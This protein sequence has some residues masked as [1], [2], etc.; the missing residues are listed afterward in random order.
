MDSKGIRLKTWMFAIAAAALVL[1]LPKPLPPILGF[2]IGVTTLAAAVVRATTKARWSSSFAW[3]LAFY[4]LVVLASVYACWLAAWIELGRP[5]RP[6]A[7]DPKDLGAAV[8]A[9]RV[10][11]SLGL[12]GLLPAAAVGFPVV[13]VRVYTWMME[14]PSPAKSAAGLAAAAT[15]GWALPF[16]L[17]S[18]DPGWVF[19]WFFD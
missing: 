5:P 8:V 14:R 2:A 10:A 17:S 13:M 11:A 4:P 15:L 6:S 18:R 9:C 19:L 3:G 1:A 16:L 7:D 12:M